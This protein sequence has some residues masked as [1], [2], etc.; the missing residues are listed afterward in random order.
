[1]QNALK[2]NDG[3]EVRVNG[4]YEGV[5]GMSGL[6]HHE[7]DLAAFKGSRRKG[8]ASHLF[9]DRPICK[10]VLLRLYLRWELGLQ[11][12]ALPRV[13]IRNLKRYRLRS[14]VD[15]LFGGLGKFPHTLFLYETFVRLSYWDELT[16][17][18][19][20]RPYYDA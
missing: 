15:L 3:P 16:N 13:P 6:D 11:N 18:L 12:A 10:K 4:V 5:V 14:L 20:V 19:L 7:F 2:G 17:S 1:V 8:V 9:D